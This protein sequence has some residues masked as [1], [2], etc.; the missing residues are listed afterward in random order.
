MAWEQK[1]SMPFPLILL[2]EAIRDGEF[3]EARFV[4]RRPQRQEER[5]D[6]RRQMAP[7]SNLFPIPKFSKNLLFKKS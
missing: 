3:V 5:E 6:Q 1:R 2:C 7:R 4:Q